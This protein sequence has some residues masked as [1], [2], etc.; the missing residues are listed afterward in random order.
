MRKNERKWSEEDIYFL[1]ENYKK[2]GNKYCSE[3]LNRT[4][5]AVSKR[6]RMIGITGKNNQWNFKKEEF[7]KFIE[8]SKSISEVLLK[9]NL[10]TAGGNFMT[11]KKYINILNLNTSHFI[12]QADVAKKT[13]Q[14]FVKKPI[15]FYL[16]ENNKTSCSSSI[17]KRLYVEGLKNSECE[18]CGQGEIWNG[19]RMSLIL[20]H[21]NGN[22]YD[23]RLE[24]LRI[25]CPNCNSTLP[26]HC[27][28]K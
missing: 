3:K 15:E 1:K 16:V 8:E 19:K 7:I 10:R 20:D 25:L 6:A 17:K 11:V 18:E 26:T 21:K 14:L 12:S 5:L 2:F 27:R 24:N 13:N 28:K 9:M 4:K 22:H 23:Y